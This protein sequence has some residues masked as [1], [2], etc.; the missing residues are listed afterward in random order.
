MPEIK[1]TTI[2]DAEEMA[3]RFIASEEDLEEIS[4]KSGWADFVNTKM[5]TERGYEATDAQLTALEQGRMTGFQRWEEI[6]VGTSY[7]FPQQPER[8]V[9]R[10]LATGQFLSRVEA[11]ERLSYYRQTNEPIWKR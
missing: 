9:L 5:L 3:K 6:G 11:N 1:E 8:Q 2:E 7:P 4:S 10:D